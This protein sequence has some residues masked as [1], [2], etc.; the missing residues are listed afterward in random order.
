MEADLDLVVP[1]LIK[2]SAES[3]GFIC[4]EANKALQVGHA[5]GLGVGLTGR[6]CVRVCVSVCVCV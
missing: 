5:F 4:E 2:K 1:M 6:V 3:N